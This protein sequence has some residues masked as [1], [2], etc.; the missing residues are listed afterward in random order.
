M[1][2]TGKINKGAHADD[3][4]AA[5]VTGAG[6]GTGAGAGGAGLGGGAG[7]GGGGDPEKNSVMPAHWLLYLHSDSA[8]FSFGHPYLEFGSPWHKKVKNK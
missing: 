2:T 5:H 3:Y 4:M 8:Y 1:H 7:A 6:G